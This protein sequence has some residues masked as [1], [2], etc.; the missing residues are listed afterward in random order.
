MTIKET[1]QAV[2]AT[3]ARIR[4]ISESREFRIVVPGGSEDSAY[5]ASD[6]LD[7]IGTALH[8]MRGV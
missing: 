6:S 7:A 5:Y 3:G 1:L 8:M 4:W 2:K